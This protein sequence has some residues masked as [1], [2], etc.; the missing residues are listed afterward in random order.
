MLRNFYAYAAALHD[1]IYLLCGRFEDL[2]VSVDGAAPLD[3][4]LAR[5][6]GCVLLGSHLGSFEAVRAVGRVVKNYPINIVMYED[7]SRKISAEFERVAPELKARAI[8]PGRPETM[9]RIKE[10]LERGEI[11]GILGDR[12]FGSEKTACV[13]SW[14]HPRVFPRGRSGWQC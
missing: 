12:P 10:C 4:L 9:L 13:R 14:A 11:V 5:G 3:A 1:R 8:A 6:R 2:E 7:D